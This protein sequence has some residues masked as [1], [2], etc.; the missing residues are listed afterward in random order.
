M[1]VV[2]DAVDSEVGAVGVVVNLPAAAVVADVAVVMDIH[3]AYHA[4][5]FFA[6]IL[7]LLLL[8]LLILS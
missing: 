3:V 4:A 8:L 2:I 7:R 1:A 6:F 5:C